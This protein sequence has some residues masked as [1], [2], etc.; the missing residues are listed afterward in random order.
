M[1]DGR[2]AQTNDEV[3]GL[4]L[5]HFQ[6]FP[7]G[8]VAK[9]D[10]GIQTPADLLGRNV[11]LPGLYGANY[12]GLIALL[13]YAGVDS[14]DRSLESIGYNQVEALVS[15]QVDAVAIY[16]PNE[17]VQLRAQARRRRP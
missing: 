4:L 16:I 8:V 6:D 9:A 7:V 10:A 1:G 12:I 15:D 13:N 14:S 17:P 11:G 3:D 2:L 5:R